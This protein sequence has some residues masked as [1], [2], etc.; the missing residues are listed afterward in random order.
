MKKQTKERKIVKWLG[1]KL[2][3]IN[4][5]L[6]KFQDLPFSKEQAWWYSTQIEAVSRRV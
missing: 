4:Q 6:K 2:G 5:S 1:F 3:A